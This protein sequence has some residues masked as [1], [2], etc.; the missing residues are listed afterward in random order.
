MNDS[1]RPTEAPSYLARKTHRKSRLG[2]LE[3]KRRRVKCDETH[4]A[5]NNCTRRSTPCNYPVS[6]ATS[7]RER[8]RKVPMWR[9]HIP[10]VAFKHNYVAQL[11]LAFSALHLAREDRSREAV[12]V[13]RSTAL[14]SAAISGM[15][16]ALSKDASSNPGALWVA[17]M[18]LCFCSFGKGPQPG[19]YLV[20][21]ET[22]EPEWLGLLQGVKTISET[23]P[24]A[25][26]SVIPTS[27]KPV[28]E[29][30]EPMSPEQVVPGLGK[31]LDDLRSSVDAFRAED[32]SFEKY[33]HPLDELRNCFG[34]A[35]ERR[36]DSN[37]IKICSHMVF[38]WLYRLEEHYLATLQAKRPMALVILAHYL[39]L[40]SQ[41]EGYWYI[42]GWVP[43]I[44]EA[45]K[46]QL[47]PAYQQW[48][49]WP[50][51]SILTSPAASAA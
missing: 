45:V 21:S 15:M 33:L 8:P 47:H 7:P 30:T 23:S 34:S 4:P 42:H 48:L 35:F 18:M 16:D 50:Q 29:R 24:N 6:N 49:Q 3:C 36:I 46:R 19:Q 25:I 1:P 40:L 28:A 12:C 17:S 13:A 20:Y 2:C 26:S 22:R 14:E 11:I 38:A 44:M 31:A 10:K 51:S 41:L 9:D 39:V 43:H 37:S 27:D 32:P 5:C